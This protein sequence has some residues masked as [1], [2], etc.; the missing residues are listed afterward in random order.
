[1]ILL[2]ECDDNSEAGVFFLFRIKSGIKRTIVMFL[3][4][5]LPSMFVC[6][7]GFL[8]YNSLYLAGV[9]SLSCSFRVCI[10]LG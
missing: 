5:K 2:A 3:N 6:G 10:A 8:L 4:K 7:G 1:M 9:L